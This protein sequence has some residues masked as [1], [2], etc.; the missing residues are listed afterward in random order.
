MK[1][2]IKLFF[3]WINRV[4]E[5]ICYADKSAAGIVLPDR[6]M[7]H[8]V[9]FTNETSGYVVCV[10]CGPPQRISLGDL[11]PRIIVCVACELAGRTGARCASDE[12]SVLVPLI[13]GY[14]PDWIGFGEKLASLIVSVGSD[15]PQRVDLL[16]PI[17]LRVQAPDR[18]APA[19]Y[20][21]TPRR[22]AAA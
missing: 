8:G 1:A 19:S 20:S 3:E 18:A 7:P 12:I 6:L 17:A 10:G 9:D 11:V 14:S 15:V 13:L 21:L 22:P 5:W 2:Y 4:A 16:D